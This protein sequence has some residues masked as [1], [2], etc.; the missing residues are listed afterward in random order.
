MR[1]K[2]E[3]TVK[4]PEKIV[5][6]LFLLDVVM[7]KKYRPVYL[8][9]LAMVVTGATLYHWLEGWS[10][11]DSYYFV[12]ITLTTIGYGDLTPTTDVAK[13][14]TIFFALNGV[15]ILVTLLDAIRQLRSEEAA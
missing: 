10:W 7:S 14:L 2:I 13:V 6:K 1:K 5:M 9:I 3:Q 11:V 4:R 12:V 15:A 8:Y